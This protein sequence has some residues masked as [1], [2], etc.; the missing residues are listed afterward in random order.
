MIELRLEGGEAFGIAVDRLLHF[1]EQRFHAF[2]PTRDRGGAI[3]VTLV[4]CL[5]CWLASR[6][7]STHGRGF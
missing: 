3:S 4:R 2:E 7:T 1:A 5:G 6:L